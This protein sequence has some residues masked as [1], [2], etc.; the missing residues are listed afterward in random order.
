MLY[1]EHIDRVVGMVP[2]LMQQQAEVMVMVKNENDIANIKSALTKYAD[3]APH[4]AEITD[5]KALLF[6]GSSIKCVVIPDNEDG[7][8]KLLHEH[9]DIIM[10]IQPFNNVNVRMNANMIRKWTNLHIS[11]ALQVH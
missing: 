2:Q 4:I 11:N 9:C 3:V 6:N 8:R 1:N 10:S 7:A 5:D